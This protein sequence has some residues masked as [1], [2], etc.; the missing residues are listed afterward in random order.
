VES[1]LWW[2]LARERG[3]IRFSGIEKGRAY[4]YTGVAFDASTCLFDHHREKPSAAL[5]WCKIT[6]A[7]IVCQ[8]YY[9]ILIS[10]SGLDA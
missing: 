3:H 6:L 4:L 7:P 2:N 8:F 5:Q 10:L 1:K 9:C